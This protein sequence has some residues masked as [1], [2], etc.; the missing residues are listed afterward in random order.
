MGE[1]PVRQDAGYRNGHG[2][3]YSGGYGNDYAEEWGDRFEQDGGSG[4]R[5]PGV[6]LS[7]NSGIVPKS[8]WGR[9]AAGCGLVV[10]AGVG[11]VG[12]LAV[13]SFLLRDEHFEVE[14][15]SSIQIAG[16]SH[17]TRAQLLS[18]FG[19]DVERNIFRI[20]L[21][22]RRAELESL[23][24]VAH[25][26][27]MRLLPNR[28]RVAIVERTPVAFVREG[29]EI[30]LVDANGVLLDLAR[31]EDSD[32]ADGAEEDA[33]ARKAPAYSFPVLT[34]ISAADPL[35]TRVARMKIYLGFVGA[36][37]AA[38]EKISQRLSEVDVSNPEDVKAIL[39]DGGAGGAD[40]LVHFG[41]S[42]FLERY[43]QYRDHL[44]EWR[45]QYPK[46]QS[47]DMRYERQVVLEMQPGTV[48]GEGAEVG[49]A[50]ES[51]AATADS[52]KAPLGAKSK[53][54]GGP[55]NSGRSEPTSQ[56]R[57]VGD[58]AVAP[59]KTVSVS[60]GHPAKSSG[61]PSAV[62]GIEGSPR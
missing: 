59:Q 51:P 20:P 17:L 10:L 41:D 12:A 47:V 61:K 4:A 44:A 13:R 18:V 26:T 16:N 8:L 48:S 23:P 49:G 38:G 24:W 9:I 43:R 50:V 56:K 15:A 19:G 60:S 2:E 55:V 3:G 35:S 14:S 46:L 21:A 62:V 39:P 27:V 54:V 36:L 45:A 57:D 1:M 33:G 31:P 53:V 37:D 42:R 34:G 30:G 29:K 52:A 28:V 5:R 11:V 25:A 22:E 32:G 7:F 40:L 6:R 58:P